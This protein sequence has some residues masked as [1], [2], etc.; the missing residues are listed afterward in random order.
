MNED[1]LKERVYEIHSVVND[2]LYDAERGRITWK[3]A[4]QQLEMEILDDMEEDI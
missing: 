3:E 4:L 1:R 2:I